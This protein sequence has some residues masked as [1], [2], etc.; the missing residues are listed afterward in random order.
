MEC[1]APV[2]NRLWSVENQQGS[3][4]PERMATTDSID[5]GDTSPLWDSMTSHRVPPPPHPNSS[6]SGFASPHLRA[7]ALIPRYRFSDFS[8][9]PDPENTS[10]SPTSPAPNPKGIPPQKP[11]V[12]PS[13]G[14]PWVTEPKTPPTPMGLCLRRP[15]PTGRNPSARPI[16]LGMFAHRILAA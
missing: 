12:V 10:S 14:L 11:R 2:C 1:G 3:K 13:A 4:R 6:R 16:G 15:G 7:F 5:C 9:L 8:H